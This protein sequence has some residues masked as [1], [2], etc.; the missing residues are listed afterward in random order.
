MLTQTRLK[1]LL[2]YDPETGYFTRNINIQGF[3]AGERAGGIT[4]K[5]YIAIGVDRKI[6]LA[7]RLA[8][9]YMTGEWPKE[10]VDHKDEVKTNNKWENLREATNQENK[11]NVG[12]RKNS[13]TGVKGVSKCKSG[14]LVMFCVGT[15]KTL[16]EAKEA[17]A[18][19]AT[20]YHGEFVH[21]KSKVVY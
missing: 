10:L 9:L 5:G 3:Y 17:Y 15:Y 19:M 16:E 1:E 7:H 8:F 21:S 4:S 12:A 14:Y 2:T 20:L 11:R 13:K 18:K 6:Y